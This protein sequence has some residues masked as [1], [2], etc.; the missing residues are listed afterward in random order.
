MK[1]RENRPYQTSIV[2]EILSK[3]SKRGVKKVGAFVSC[4]LGKTHIGCE[5]AR[6]WAAEGKRVLISAYALSE[7]RDNWF[8]AVAEY[9]LINL[10]DLQVVVPAGKLGLY[11]KRY[12]GVF[13]AKASDLCE[14]RKVIITLPQSVKKIPFPVDRVLVDEAHEHYQV[15]S[16]NGRGRLE[17]IIGSCLSKRGKIVAMTGTG[18][19]LVESGDFSLRK[20]DVEYVVRDM[21]F[22]IE[23]GKV[24]PVEIHME[25]FEFPLKSSCYTKSGDLKKS[26]AKEVAKGL[27]LSGKGRMVAKSKTA[28]RLQ[29]EELL[30]SLA[31]SKKTLVI[32]PAG[33]EINLSVQSKINAYMRKNHGLQSCAVV[34]TSRQSEAANE[35]AEREFRNNPNVKFM[36]AVS[37]CGTGW[38]FPRLEN[39]VDLSFTRNKKVI[40]QRMSRACRHHKGK[41]PRY[42]FCSDQRAHPADVPVLLAQAVNLTTE[43]GM[44]NPLASG[45]RVKV[46]KKVLNRVGRALSGRGSGSVELG[47]IRDYF[48]GGRPGV[49]RSGT[50]IVSVS[51]IFKSEAKERILEMLHDKFGDL[52]QKD[53]C[54]EKSAELARRINSVAK[55]VPA[56]TPAYFEALE[57]TMDEYRSEVA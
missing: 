19:E 28:K 45:D 56:D 53:L 29:I 36:V 47:D 22:A 55:T 30:D 33:D 42:Y 16:K 5:L 43:E 25:F 31:P 49:N 2:K 4:G 44:L 32:V 10:G 48:I 8:E 18:F 7:I 27:S 24:M 51:D 17:S 35:R 13:F 9:G 15:K 37:M 46:S 21:P 14:K 40:I 39:V 34:K 12:P 52:R 20:K 41:R 38:D 23:T 3:L 6:I 1:K 54:P 57:K 11:Q 26:G 50:E